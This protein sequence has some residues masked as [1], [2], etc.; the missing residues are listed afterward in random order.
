MF[1][2]VRR[3]AQWI[4]FVTLPEPPGRLPLI[5]T[6]LSSVNSTTMS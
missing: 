2:S 4:P 3:L 6:N 5:Q 1:D